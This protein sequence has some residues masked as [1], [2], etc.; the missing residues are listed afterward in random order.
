MTSSPY[1][2]IYILSHFLKQHNHLFCNYYTILL[3]SLSTA[4]WNCSFLISKQGDGETRRNCPSVRH[5]SVPQMSVE[6]GGLRGWVTIRT[7][8]FARWYHSSM[9]QRFFGKNVFLEDQEGFGIWVHS[10]ERYCLLL[11]KLVLDGSNFNFLF[12]L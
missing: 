12:S 10:S 4:N 3:E 9:E 6:G 5:C 8:I 11:W 2:F 1:L 7:H